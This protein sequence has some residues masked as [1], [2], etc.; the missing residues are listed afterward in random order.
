[1]SRYISLLFTPM[2][3]FFFFDVCFVQIFR[4]KRANENK[5]QQQEKQQ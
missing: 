1:M 5:T 3:K 4:T 2:F